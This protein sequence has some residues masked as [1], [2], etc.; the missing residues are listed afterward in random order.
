MKISKSW[1]KI[2]LEITIDEL[3]GLMCKIPDDNKTAVAIVEWIREILR[4]KKEDYK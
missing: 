4:T 2:E 3:I 1:F